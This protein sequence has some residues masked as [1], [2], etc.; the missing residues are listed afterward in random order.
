MKPKQSV[1]IVIR[2]KQISQKQN[3]SNQIKSNQIR[4]RQVSKTNNNNKM[5]RTKREKWNKK[6]ENDG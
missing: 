1:G 4:V 2:T 3:K 5:M 6:R